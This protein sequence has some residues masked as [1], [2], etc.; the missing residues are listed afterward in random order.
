MRP[1]YPA[2][3]MFALLAATGAMAGESSF[4]SIDW[5]FGDQTSHPAVVAEAAKQAPP[6]KTGQAPQDAAPAPQQGTDAQPAETTETTNFENWILSCRE[7]VEGPKK[8]TCAMTVA[9][10]KTDT[11]R[12]VLSWTVRQNEKGQPIS[13]VETLPGVSIGPGIQLKLETGSAPH[14]VPIEICEPAWC[15]GTLAMDKAFVQE[16][17]ASSKVS[18]IVTSSAGQPITFEFPIKG[19]EKAYAKM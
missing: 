13:V 19:F 8:R 4:W 6:S 12:I 7:F 15:S 3:S 18:I 17:T 2:V 1:L 10:R 9:V 11:N 14:K 16:V 5:L